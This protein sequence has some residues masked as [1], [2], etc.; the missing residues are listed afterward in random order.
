M[1]TEI[2]R[3]DIRLANLKA[4][5]D[6]VKLNFYYTPRKLTNNSLIFNKEAMTEWWS[7][8][9]ESAKQKYCKNYELVKR[10]KPKLIRDGMN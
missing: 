7:E 8:G 2:G 4:L 9:Y 5:Q 1:M 10:R 3:D 6:D